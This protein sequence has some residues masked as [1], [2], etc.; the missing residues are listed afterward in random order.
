MTSLHQD[1][2]NLMS[3]FTLTLRHLYPLSWMRVTA[4]AAASAG[5]P[6]QSINPL[7]AM[8]SEDEFEVLDPCNSDAVLVSR[9]CEAAERMAASKPKSKLGAKAE[10]SKPRVSRSQHAKSTCKDSLTL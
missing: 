8:V 2:V 7:T 9:T 4:L 10:E 5:L 1:S 6:E 3:S